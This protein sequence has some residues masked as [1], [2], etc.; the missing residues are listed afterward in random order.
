MFSSMIFAFK[1]GSSFLAITLE[2]TRILRYCLV[3]LTMGMDGDRWFT[4]F[5]RGGLA[6]WR[7]GTFPDGPL[8]SDGLWA[9]W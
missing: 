4:E 6:I 2:I 9:D 1:L 7:T 5:F 8:V 3:I